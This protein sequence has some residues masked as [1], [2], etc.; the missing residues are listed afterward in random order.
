M[1]CGICAELCPSRA[2]EIVGKEYTVD[3]LYQRLLKDEPFIRKGDGGITFSGGEPLLQFS[4]LEELSEKLK[5]HN[6]HLALDTAGNV[7]P[8][9]YKKLLPYIDL[10][11]FDLK[12][13]DNRKHKKFTGAGNNRII[14]NLFLI[15]DIIKRQKL[16][17]RIWIRTPLIPGMTGTEENIS[18]IGE[19]L[20]IEFADITD[21]WELLGYNNMCGEKYRKLGFN[22]A[23]EEVELLSRPEAN[24]LLDIARSSARALK[25]IVFSGLTYREE[26]NNKK[27]SG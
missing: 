24:V 21:R 26:K 14:N 11:L 13:L 8:E 15:R 20:S 18:A 10:V 12:E 25:K 7:E 19:L 5:K 1:A 17:T 6:F 16:K 22:W 3:E 27:T 23:L 9:N 2:L 4:F